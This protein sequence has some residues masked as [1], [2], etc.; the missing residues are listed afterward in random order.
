MT[1]ENVTQATPSSAEEEV[2]ELLLFVA[3][4][5]AAN[6]HVKKRLERICEAHVPGRYRIRTLDIFENP[7]EAY[8]FDIIAT[9]TVLRRNPTPIRRV[10]GNLSLVDKVLSGLGLPPVD[11]PL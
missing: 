8:E 5:E 7:G 6:Q 1:D 10:I 4:S 11:E 9:P 3:G 2:W